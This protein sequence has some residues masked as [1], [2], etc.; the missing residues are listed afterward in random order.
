M[1]ESQVTSIPVPPGWEILTWGWRWPQYKLGVVFNALTLRDTL[2]GREVVASGELVP[3]GGVV[4]NPD[5][6]DLIVGKAAFVIDDQS[7]GTRCTLVLSQIE[8]Y[9]KPDREN[10]DPDTLQGLNEQW[11]KAVFVDEYSMLQQVESVRHQR[12]V[13][14]QLADE[15][16]EETDG[17]TR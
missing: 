12:K 1:G 2:Q 8:I 5:A 3:W 7:R 10:S 4:K 14:R 9:F 11:V 17:P 13:M 16:D 15:L 6:R